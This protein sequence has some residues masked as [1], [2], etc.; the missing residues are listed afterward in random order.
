VIMLRRLYSWCFSSFL[1]SIAASAIAAE[2]QYLLSIAVTDSGVIYLADRSLPGVWKLENEKLTLFSQGSKMFRTP[3]NAIRC[4]AVDGEGNPLAGDS[5]TRDVYRF[6]D[7]GKPIGL[8]QKSVDGG[9]GEAGPPPASVNKA[10]EEKEP[11]D[12]KDA[13]K[14]DAGKSATK[15]PASKFVFGEIGIPMDIAVNSAGDLLVS[16]LET[17]RIVKIARSDGSVTEFAKVQAPRGL[18]MDAEQNLWAIS[19]RKLVRVSAA[20]EKSTVVED[21]TFN[22]PHTVAVG[23]DKTA[24]VCDGYEKCIWK[25]ASGSKPE[26]L[27]SGK[28]FV[29]PVGM[30]LAG[31][32][33]YVADPHAKAVF[34]ITLDGKITSLPLKQ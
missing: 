31:D 22:F 24:Y 3:L 5:A 23:S 27:V 7:S 17:H 19:G 1:I 10:S 12:K 30:R 14:K 18:C 32:K 28:P 13:D 4:V 34:Q 33:L 25:I 29:N 15:P 11:S 9:A 20:G 6:D 8:T 16:D 26:K 21:G 2:P